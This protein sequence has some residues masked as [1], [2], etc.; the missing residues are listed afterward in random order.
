M[1]F[2]NICH[3]THQTNYMY[4]YYVCMYV[5]MYV[6]M[7]GWMDGWMDVYMYVCVRVYLYVYIHTCR[8]PLNDHF[9]KETTLQKDH[10]LARTEFSTLFHV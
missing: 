10:F 7:D 5:C 9:T 6:W 1:D 3:I 4:R 2:I 8:D